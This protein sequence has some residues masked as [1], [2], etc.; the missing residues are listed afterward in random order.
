MS[1]VYLSKVTGHYNILC[2]G[3]RVFHSIAVGRLVNDDLNKPTFTGSLG[4]TGPVGEEGL[5]KFCH[6]YIENG[7]I[8][9]LDDCWHELKGTEVE[10]PEVDE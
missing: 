4:W 2:P 6:S 5:A 3:C 9:F 1:K 10:L 7:R 8:R